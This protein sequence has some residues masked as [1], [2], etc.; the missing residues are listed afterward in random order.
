VVFEAI[1]QLL[2]VKRKPKPK[3]GFTVKEQIKAYGKKRG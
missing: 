1:K 3:I 2:E